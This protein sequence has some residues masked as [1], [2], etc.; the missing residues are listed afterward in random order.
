MTKLI[1]NLLMYFKI[2]NK[3]ILDIPGCHLLRHLPPQ[4]FIHNVT[5]KNQTRNK[6]FKGNYAYSDGDKNI[7]V[8]IYE[9]LLV[10]ILI[11]NLYLKNH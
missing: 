11:N 3:E 7:H 1:F 9:F 10:K 2:E 4:L 6:F 8:F 5:I